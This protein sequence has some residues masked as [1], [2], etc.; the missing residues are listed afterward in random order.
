MDELYKLPINFQHQFE[1]PIWRV[2]FDDIEDLLVVETRNKKQR[3]T[4]FSTI[5]LVQYKLLWQDKSFDD[6]WWI[7][8]GAAHKGKIVF[9]YYEDQN[10]PTQRGFFVYDVFREQ[11]IWEDHEHAYYTLLKEE[12]ALV[13]FKRGESIPRYAAL[14]LHTGEPQRVHQPKRGIKRLFEQMAISPIQYNQHHPHFDTLTQFIRSYVTDAIPRKA[15]DYI[16]DNDWHLLGY[17]LS[18]N[19]NNV[20]DYYLLVVNHEGVPF[21]HI[22]L[23][24]DLRNTYADLFFVLKNE[25]IVVRNRTDL[26]SFQL[27][28]PA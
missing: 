22:R 5:D 3:K 12:D 21:L 24:Q 14:N 26:I 8:I 15:V 28:R 10:Q 17:Y 13:V 4:F 7:S 1:L 25:L 9:F 23:D 16:E 27:Q 2:I 18:H 6:P 20:L 19:N 11:K